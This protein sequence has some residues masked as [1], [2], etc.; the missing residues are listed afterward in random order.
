MI[1]S[2]SLDLSAWPRF[3][4]NY[5][6]SQKSTIKIVSIISCQRANERESERRVKRRALLKATPFI[7][8]G[9]W[10]GPRWMHSRTSKISI[11]R[12]KERGMKHGMAWHISVLVLPA[13]ILFAA[14]SLKNSIS[15]QC[16][17]HAINYHFCL[18]HFTGSFCFG[19]ARARA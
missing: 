9:W 4:I 2:L 19:P 5:Q 1:L 17:S 10:N 12:D 7:V 8:L 16:Q 6:N 3:A 14:V 18:T 15:C 11:R 13:C